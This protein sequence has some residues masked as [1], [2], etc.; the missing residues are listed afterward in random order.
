VEKPRTRCKGCNAPVQFQPGAG[1]RLCPFCTTINLVREQQVATPA[2]ELK[3][4]ELFHRAQRGDLQGAREE[5][6]KILD[7]AMLN[8]R[9][10]FYR[11]CFL[12]E[13]KQT[14][15]AVFALIDLTGVDAP[16][17]LR[18]DMHAKLAEALLQTGRVE[19]ALESSRKCLE[20]VEGH[21]TGVLIQARILVQ[22]QKTGEAARLLEELLPSLAKQWKITFPP[23]RSAVLLFLAQVCL[24]DKRNEKA[25]GWLEALLLQETAAPLPVVVETTRLLADSLLQSKFTA[26]SG[27]Q[28]LRLG[29]F[30][31]PENRA[32]LLEAMRQASSQCG[33]N[34]QT[35]TEGFI[36]AR[37]DLLREIRSAMCVQVPSLAGNPAIVTPTLELSALA[38]D[39]DARTDILEAVALRLEIR[40]FDRGTLYPV[41]TVEDFRRWAAAWRLR[42]LLAKQKRN[43]IETQRVAGLK[44]V[45][46]ETPLPKERIGLTTGQR[47]AERRRHLGLWISLGALLG[48]LLAA[49]F[50]AVAGDRFLD[51]FEGRLIKIECLGEN[52]G[53]P[54]TLLVDGGEPARSRFKAREADPSWVGRLLGGWLDQRVTADGT[55]S[56]PLRFLW[57]NFSAAKYEPCIGQPIKKLRFTLSP[58]CLPK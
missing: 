4:D 40:R 32:G 46:V 35:E 39:P 14:K 43:L 3:V 16:A 10:A 31:D 51:A 37:E 41:R 52:Q 55:L 1:A 5:A 58:V 25:A 11:A 22:M 45:R 26:E 7:P 24:K 44:G 17:P 23:H 27:L 47:Q 8:V 42:E 13:L 19:E 33:S 30:L 56:Y 12:L 50:L 2:L 6:E 29:A 34:P 18:A 54:C 49:G 53:P 48:L 21:P 15:D 57:G 38:E 28:L 9:L 36:Q 20:L